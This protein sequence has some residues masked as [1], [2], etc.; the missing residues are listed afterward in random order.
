MQIKT[1]GHKTRTL[2]ICAGLPWQA[3]HEAGIAAMAVDVCTPDFLQ[4]EHAVAFPTLGRPTPTAVDLNLQQFRDAYYPGWIPLARWHGGYKAYRENR[5]IRI[6][7]H[8]QLVLEA[9]AEWR[10][11][12]D[13]QRSIRLGAEMHGADDTA[14]HG[15]Y[16]PFWD[17]ANRSIRPRRT[18]RKWPPTMWW[19][20][21]APPILHA[22]DLGEPDKIEGWG[23]GNDPK[24]RVRTRAKV[25]FESNALFDIVQTGLPNHEHRGE[26]LKC[27][28]LARN[29]KDFCRRLNLLA[30]KIAGHKLPPLEVWPR[31]NDTWK[32][33]FAAIR[34]A[35]I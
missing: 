17:P 7:D 22:Q 1:H 23:R 13:I 16:T 35:G 5:A 10:C 31:G 21:I 12:N 30:V 27:I 2:L 9:V 32:Y 34:E 33:F 25:M 8:D 19:G 15:G 26:F 14:T 6:G 11:N 20:R 4:K 24:V 3:A 28:E 18:R 29:D